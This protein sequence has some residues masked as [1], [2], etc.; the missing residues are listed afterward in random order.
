MFDFKHI[1]PFD[2]SFADQQG[3]QVLIATPGMLHAGLSLDVFKKWAG[4]PLNMCILPGY[5]VVGTVGNKLLAGQRGPVEIDK[6]TV[7]DVKCQVIN[8]SFSAHADAKGI[9]QLIRLANPLNVM[10]VHGEKGKMFAVFLLSF[11]DS[12]RQFLKQKI[13]DKFKIPCFDPPNGTTVVIKTD[14]SIP[15]LLS[16]SL[17][18][19]LSADSKASIE[20]ASKKQKHTSNTTN[21]LSIPV[22]IHGVLLLSSTHTS[23][24]NS[25][26][27]MNNETQTNL[28]IESKSATQEVLTT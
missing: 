21:S 7:I 2:R 28:A 4:N 5:C 18:N 9:M 15:I 16:S 10:L 13:I 1:K 3:A 22:Q 27:S 17:L 24:N 19:Q 20:P 12:F 25:V 6:K 8:L 26:D 23:F 11:I 14:Y